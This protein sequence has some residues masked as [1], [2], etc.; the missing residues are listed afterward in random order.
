MGDLLKTVANSNWIA[1]AMMGVASGVNAYSAQSNQRKYTNSQEDMMNRGRAYDLEAREYAKKEAD[2]YNRVNMEN[3]AKNSLPTTEALGA[4][5]AQNRAQAGQQALGAQ[6]SLYSNLAARGF[7]PSSG[8]ME[9]GLTGIEKAKASSMSSMATDLTK[10]ANTRQ[11]APPTMVPSSN[12]IQGSAMPTNMQP[13]SG[14]STT[15]ALA[16]GLGDIGGYFS[17]K[18]GLADIM[19]LIG[20]GS[21]KTPQYRPVNTGNELQF[22][23]PESTYDEYEDPRFART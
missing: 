7:G 13:Y 19:K 21:N 11:F 16:Q 18:Q 4:Q 20:S 14:Q 17:R 23:F 6:Q 9:R 22:G 5:A 2:E 3:W 1:P 15:G 12:W 8:A 10:F